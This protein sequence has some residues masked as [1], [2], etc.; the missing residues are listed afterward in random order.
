M[1]YESADKWDKRVEERKKQHGLSKFLT[2]TLLVITFF[3]MIISTLKDMWS[4]RGE[5][6]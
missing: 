2:G 4:N 1:S 6:R 3:P 5:N